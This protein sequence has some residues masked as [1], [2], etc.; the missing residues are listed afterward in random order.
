MLFM[1]SLFYSFYWDLPYTDAEGLN[2]F[3]YNEQLQSKKETP[4]CFMHNFMLFCCWARLI[5]NDQFTIYLQVNYVF[6]E[7]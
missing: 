6:N 7:E 3:S 1:K 5:L 2:T 4:N